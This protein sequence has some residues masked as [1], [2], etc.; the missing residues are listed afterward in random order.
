MD[1]S[2]V[3]HQLGLISG[4][5]WIAGAVFLIVGLIFM[6]RDNS[7]EVFLPAAMLTCFSLFLII[8]ATDQEMHTGTLDKTTATIT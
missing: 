7:L 6:W 3:T 8:S 5:L 4:G 2:Y 1:Y